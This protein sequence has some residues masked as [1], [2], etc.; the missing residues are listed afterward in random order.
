MGTRRIQHEDIDIPEHTVSV[1][2][3]YDVHTWE[4][5]GWT[6][7]V[8]IYGP[9]FSSPRPRVTKFGSYM[10]VEYR[11]HCN[12]L[13]ATLAHTRHWLEAKGH[14]YDSSQPI[15]LDIAFW[16]KK[17]PGDIDNLAKTIMDAGQRSAKDI[18]GGELWS[19][20]KNI[21]QLTAEWVPTDSPEWWQTVMRFRPA[22][23]LRPTSPTPTNFD[24][25]EE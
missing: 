7:L 3:G 1:P 16:C 18:A 13:K 24:D 22:R 4:H 9:I 14:V 2:G 23:S 21:R 25:E 5:I 6:V 12:R 19:N 17:Q 15:H 10:P 20:D 8:H 11:N